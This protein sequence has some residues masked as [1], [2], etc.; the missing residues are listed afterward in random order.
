[1]SQ[2]SS[3][4]LLPLLEGSVDPDERLDL[5]EGQRFF[6]LKDSVF[7]RE[8]QSL[9]HTSHWNRRNFGLLG[10]IRVVGRKLKLVNIVVVGVILCQSSFL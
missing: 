5:I 1:M 10:R 2:P 6:F 9:A 7:S 3:D 8:Y 4:L